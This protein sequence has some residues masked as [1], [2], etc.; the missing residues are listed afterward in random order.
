MF[1][2]NSLYQPLNI[3]PAIHHPPPIAFTA[4]LRKHN[5]PEEQSLWDCCA[6]LT[7]D[8]N[9][10]SSHILVQPRNWIRLLKIQRGTITFEGYTLIPVK[11]KEW[12]FPSGIVIVSLQSLEVFLENLS[13]AER[14]VLTVLTHQSSYCYIWR[15]LLDRPSH[16]AFLT[17]FI[18]Y[19]PKEYSHHW[20][21]FL[22]L[23]NELLSLTLS[24][25]LSFHHF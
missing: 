18:A 25:H 10:K 5:S 1:S 23:I 17:L 3:L 21:S 11:S 2:L 7:G 6:E 16:W 13:R 8:M 19:F 15:D 12:V 24:F 9:N 4:L 20:C 14:F 22:C